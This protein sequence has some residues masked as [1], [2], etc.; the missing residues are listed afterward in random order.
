MRKQE[1]VVE[2]K[3]I[4]SERPHKF[5][6]GVKAYENTICIDNSIYKAHFY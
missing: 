3:S 2:I 5:Y 1:R 4:S 6:F